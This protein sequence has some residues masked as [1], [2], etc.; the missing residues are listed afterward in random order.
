[1][2]PAPRDFPTTMKIPPLFG[3]LGLAVLAACQS[4]PHARPLATAAR[5]DLQRYA[6][7]W[8]EVARLPNFFQKAGEQAI[9]EYRLEPDGRVAVRNTAVR[10]DGQKRSIE[11]HATAVPGSN[12]ARLMVRFQGWAGLAPVSNRGNYWVIAVDP[13]YRYAMVGTP[14]RKY[15]WILARTPQLDPRIRQQLME[16]AK[17]EGFA[18]ER[19][20]SDP[21]PPGALSDSHRS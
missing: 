9:A 14:D 5:V 21:S 13:Q 7:T 4:S 3:F 2:P 17:A 8:Y 1:M 11:G 12:H 6:G 20:L 10:P 15:L 19:L 18:T 16:R